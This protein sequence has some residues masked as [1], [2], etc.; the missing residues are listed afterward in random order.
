MRQAPK[1]LAFY[2][3]Y[4][5]GGQPYI[6]LECALQTQPNICLISEEVEAK[7][8]SLGQVVDHICASIVRRAENHE[9]FGVVL[10]PE[11]LVEFIPEMKKLI[12][13]LNDII[14]LHEKEFLAQ[15]SFIDQLYW[16]SRELSAP[17][18]ELLKSLPPEVC[19]KPTKTLELE[20]TK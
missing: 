8:L 6:A 11:G 17:S 5:P 19:D 4:G 13:E 14:A 12:E 3:T 9:N 18:D 15:S 1:I 7:A 20:H 16:L 10:I 2:Q